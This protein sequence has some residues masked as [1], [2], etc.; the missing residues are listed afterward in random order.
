[1]KSMI[2]TLAMILMTATAS[3]SKSPALVIDCG[4]GL[5]KKAGTFKQV[6]YTIVSKNGVLEGKSGRNFKVF[7]HANNEIKNAVFS[8]NEDR[9]Q[10]LLEMVRPVGHRHIGSVLFMEYPDKKILKAVKRTVGGVAG[11]HEVKM[12]CLVSEN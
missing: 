1:M 8:A 6:Y 3:A 11:G 9:S 7:G 4:V 5:D 12:N 2:L 10:L